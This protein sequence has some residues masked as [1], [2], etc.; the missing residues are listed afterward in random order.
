MRIAQLAFF[1]SFTFIS[2][3]QITLFNR[4]CKDSLISVDAYTD[5][6]TSINSSF[7]LYPSDE[8]M[9]D[10][11][12]LFATQIW[13]FTSKRYSELQYSEM[14]SQMSVFATES[15]RGSNYESKK[16][17]SKLDKR[18]RRAKRNTTAGFTVVKCVSFRINLTETKGKRVYCDEMDG[19]GRFNLFY[20]RRI[21]EQEKEEG[22]VPIPVKVL[23]IEQ[24]NRKLIRALKSQK[25]YNDLHKGVYSSLGIS[26]V[27]DKKTVGKNTF[28]TARVVVLLGAK[29]LQRIKIQG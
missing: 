27:L 16:K 14:L 18:F 19:D 12:E 24:L 1:L 7:E 15:W 26:V 3:T 25:V 17:W 2:S 11:S 21:S 13:Q 22:K 4:L 6:N 8:S 5:I 28:P 23:N 10:L 9:N 20:G 29:R